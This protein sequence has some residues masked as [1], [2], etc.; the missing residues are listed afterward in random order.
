MK[1]GRLPPNPATLAA[2]PSLATHRMSA[3][4]PERVLDRS[5]TAFTPALCGNDILPVC[6]A[7][8]LRNH[9]AG[10]AAICGFTLAADDAMVPAF[11]AGCVGCDLTMPAMEATDGAVIS[12]V[13]ARQA[14]HGFD[15]GEQVLLAARYATLPLT[16]TAL[17]NAMCR[18]GGAYLGIVLHDRDMQTVGQ[19]WDIGL[20][21]SSPVGGHCVVGWDYTGLGDADTVRLM[22]WGAWQPATWR[23]LEARV[24]EAWGL[25]W[26][27]PTM[28]DGVDTGVDLA[29][30]AG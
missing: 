4:V 15:L 2:L 20:R 5:S 14:A 8:G 18:L 6:T 1:L 12:D 26:G 29:G 17:A 9:A 24:E 23:W 30:L 13:L 11:Y 25:A 16:R 19:T 22:T 3:F 7:V 28:P 27:Y 21:G 10:V